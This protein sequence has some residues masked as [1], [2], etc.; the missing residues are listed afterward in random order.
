VALELTALGERAGIYRDG[1]SERLNVAVVRE[2]GGL[3]LLTPGCASDLREVGRRLVEPAG[4]NEL[5]DT[6]G[7]TDVRPY[8]AAVDAAAPGRGP[9]VEDG[10]VR[11]PFS[12]RERQV[13]TLLA[14]GLSDRSIAHELLISP[15]TVE[16]HVGAVLR[17]TGT[18]SR[19]AAVM[20]AL[21]RGWLDDGTSAV[22]LSRWG[23][24]PIPSGDDLGL[25]VPTSR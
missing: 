9:G 23:N 11:S 18:S 1:L 14:R 15:K 8:S 3:H 5:V 22:R 6:A 17:K 24:S 19:T 4:W 20:C 16:K 2:G 10:P 21:E 25:T 7:G 12:L 13:A